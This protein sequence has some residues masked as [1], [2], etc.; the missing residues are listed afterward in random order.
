V[1]AAGA[2]AAV[3]GAPASAE[4]MPSAHVFGG[5]GAIG[6][7]FV[8]GPHNTLGKHFCTGSVVNS[9][10]GDLVITAAHC[11]Q[12]KSSQQ[13]AFVPEYHAGH[14]P[15]GVWLVRAMLRDGTGVSGSPDRDIAF[16]L[17][18]RAGS[19]KTL[20]SMTGGEGLGE[21]AAH[22]RVLTVG[23]PD[24][25]ARPIGCVNIIRVVGR[26][27][28]EFDCGGYTV[29]TSG[30]P[31]IAAF[32]P[33]TGLGV[34]VGV[35]G[36]YQQGGDTAAVSYTARFGHQLADLYAKAVTMRAPAPPRHHHRA[37]KLGVRG[38]SCRP[39]ARR[40]VRVRGR[41]GRPAHEGRGRRPREARDAG[42]APRRG[43]AAG[44]RARVRGVRRDPGQPRPRRVHT[45]AAQ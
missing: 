10:G 36:G 15:Y 22:Q 21:P 41:R 38:G 43:R 23:Y 6:A 42:G 11:L 45:A 5:V 9:P 28:V 19:T 2:L 33:V 8:R 7:L 17:V 20:Q 16:M 25:G 18:G 14:E 34:I 39:V 12:G 13:I 37:R 31:L 4:T 40:G 44:V 35:I 24:G 26:N 27:P 1:I 3:P 32:N 29:G 30:G